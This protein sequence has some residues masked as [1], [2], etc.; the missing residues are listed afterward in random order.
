[1]SDPY[2]TLGVS[3]T[4]SEAEIKKAYRK[5]AKQYHP[6]TNQNTP[7][8]AEKFAAI[9]TAYDLLSDKTKRAQF[10]RGEID[11]QGNPKMPFGAGAGGTGP[12]GAGGPF[13]GASPFGGRG[14]ASHFEVNGETVDI[15]D[16]FG[17]MFGGGRA[18]G[19][20][21][22][23][24]ARQQAAPKGETVH[25][26]LSVNFEDAASLKP[27]RIT[28]G[29]G[30]A[31]DLKLPAG[32][33][34]GTQMRLAG[35][36]QPGPGG[37]GDAVVTIDIGAHRFFTR[38]GDHVR[39]DLPIT[40]DEAVNGGSVKVPTVDGAVMLN[41]PPATASG[42][43]MRLRAKGFTGKSGARGDQLVRL[44]IDLP[45]DDAELRAFAARWRD[46]RS[47]RAGLGV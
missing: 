35:K 11:A 34:S 13:G 36:G 3:R 10:D 8:A 25:Y 27:Q 43:V 41:I 4:A 45:N 33:E 32:V 47:V 16:L 22:F 7:K 40:L 26:R 39:L 6:D 37:P 28:L 20:S 29:D 15:G 21:P 2:A 31:I 38:D 14:G 17:G 12:F 19:A 24:G 46:S 42:T 9:T 44:L 30:K 1:M 23:G 5:L 18:R